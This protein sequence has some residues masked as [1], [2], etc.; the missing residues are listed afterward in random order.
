MFCCSGR[1][2]IT[3][4][5]CQRGL[6]PRLAK[7]SHSEMWPECASVGQS[8]VRKERKVTGD[9]PHCATQGSN[10]MCISQSCDRQEDTIYDWHWAKRTA[11][12]PIRY[13]KW[14]ISVNGQN[15]PLRDL[16][17]STH[18]SQP[19]RHEEERDWTHDWS[20]RITR[21]PNQWNC[22]CGRPITWR[23]NSIQT[24]T[25]DIEYGYWPS[26]REG[27]QCKQTIGRPW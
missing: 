8:G 6:Q 20:M 5:R 25:T 9:W 27:K 14:F 4:T 22:V 16:I 23:H 7:T 1:Q 2:P 15:A 24:T 10:G 19:I 21:R 11:H 13:V 12:Q 17:G 3:L 18:V 26:T